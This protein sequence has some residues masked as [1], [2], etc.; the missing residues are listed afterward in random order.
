MD[1]RRTKYCPKFEDITRKKQELNDEILK[2]HPRARD[3]HN[4]ISNNKNKYKLKFIKIYNGKCAY[5]G[6]SIDLIQKEFFE[7]DHFI[8]EKASC[9]NSKKD[10]GYIDNLIL[11][12]HSCN[13][14]KS[15]FLVEKKAFKYLFPDNK[16]IQS[17]FV[18]TDDYYIKINDKYL[19]NNNIKEFYKKLNLG[20]EL[21]RLDYLLLNIGGL[22]DKCKSNRELYYELGQIKDALRIK[23]NIA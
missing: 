17:T 5:C 16:K 8:N 3:M 4:Y 6:A 9:F 15:S 23:R 20:A 10:A 12:C 14:N 13:H 7:I 19:T 2:E 22:Q 21:H 18:R 1:Y 11:A